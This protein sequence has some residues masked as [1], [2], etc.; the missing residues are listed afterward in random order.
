MKNKQ[1]HITETSAALMEA[2]GKWALE[3]GKG[4]LVIADQK[5]AADSLVHNLSLRQGS[6]SGC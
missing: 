1:L 3:Q 6:L 2:A 4:V 5:N